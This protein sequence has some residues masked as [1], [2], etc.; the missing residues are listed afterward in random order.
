MVESWESCQVVP[1]VV[2]GRV[3]VVIWT[4][5]EAVEGK[6]TKSRNI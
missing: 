1:A 6:W 3:M 5:V 4:R 2:Q